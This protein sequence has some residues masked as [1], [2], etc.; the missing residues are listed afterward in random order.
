MKFTEIIQSLQTK[1]QENVVRDVEL[2]EVRMNPKH[3]ERFASGA[4]GSKMTAGFEAE[5]CFRGIGGGDNGELDYEN[6]EPDFDSDE[7]CGSIDDAVR[8]FHDGDFNGRRDVQRLRERMEEAFYEWQSEQFG[9]RWIEVEDDVV[10]EYI[11]ENDWM[12]DDKI[13]EYLADELGLDASRIADVLHAGAKADEMTS[14]K[15]KNLFKS[16][17]ED[18]A[19]YMEAVDATKQML[20]D[21]VAGSIESQDRNYE[22]AREA[23]MD[24][25]REDDTEDRYSEGRWLEDNDLSTMSDVYS[26]Y[27][28]IIQWPHWSYPPMGGDGGFNRYSAIDLA[29]KLRQALDVKVKASS[30][31]HSTAREPDLWIIEEDGSL[32]ADDSDDMPC[33]IVSPPMPLPQCINMMRAFFEWAQGEDAYSN[34]STGLHVGI[35]MPGIGG[36]RNSRLDYLKLVLFLGDGQVLDDFDRIGNHYCESSLGKIGQQFRHVN[37]ADLQAA[38]DDMRDGLIEQ[39][40]NALRQ[41][42]GHGKYSSV[43]LKDDYVEFRSMGGERYLGNIDVVINT[44]QRFAYAYSIAADANAER[45]EYGKNLYKLLGKSIKSADV[46]NNVFVKYAGGE[47]TMPQSA[48]KQFL[49]QAQIQREVERADK[50]AGDIKVG[51]WEPDDAE[52]NSSLSR[53]SAEYWQQM[54]RRVVQPHRQGYRYWYKVQWR[55]SN[56]TVDVVATNPSEAIVRAKIEVPQWRTA[57]NDEFEVEATDRYV[58]AGTAPASGDG[59][60]PGSTLHRQQQRAAGSPW[61][62]ASEPPPGETDDSGDAPEWELYNRQTGHGARRF[63]AQNRGEAQQFGNM[64]LDTL[65]NSGLVAR[66]DRDQWTVRQVGQ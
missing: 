59:P 53:E 1:L 38:I 54:L 25:A 26:N 6:G 11:L 5:L 63:D 9:E 31:Y 39:A 27:D 17:D 22:A 52:W 4:I 30:G 13:E 48:L 29:R 19:T 41:T 18:Y 49:K 20:D 42:V 47:G 34:D 16:Q 64:V 8:F 57:G 21:Y 7:S 10:R 3:L 66:D 65:I 44:V 61:P 40:R 24:E 51:D 23:W 46:I 2:D 55:H 37:D 60:V 56:M 43:N 58:E 50:E 33:E 12:M 36:K 14:I 45:Q 32:R 28:G 15:Q 35:S 62:F